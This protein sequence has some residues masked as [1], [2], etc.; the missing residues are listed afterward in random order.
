MKKKSRLLIAIVLILVTAILI[1]CSQTISAAASTDTTTTPNTADTTATTTNPADLIGTI[2]NNAPSSPEELQEIAR[3]K[4]EAKLAAL[5]TLPI[6]RFLIGVD[7]FLKALSPIFKFLTGAEYSFSVYFLICMIIWIGVA[8][9]IYNPAKSMFNAKPIVAFGVAVIIPTLAGQTGVIAS[10]AAFITPLFTNPW[11]IVVA[12][13]LACAFLIF[14]S[15]FMKKFGQKMKEKN[16]EE[17]KKER[18]QNA[19]FVDE[20][21]KIK[22]RAAGA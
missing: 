21:N 4:A 20:L 9:L 13:I 2:Q 11:I 16:E 17:R 18:E 6:G 8:I 10:S 1:T 12:I 19:K 5:K 22:K 3:R 15:M 14:Y 7:N